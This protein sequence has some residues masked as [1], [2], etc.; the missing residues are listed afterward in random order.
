[1]GMANVLDPISGVD[2]NEA[3]GRFDEL[4][5]TRDDPE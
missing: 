4:R 5:R 1:M 2:E 3:L